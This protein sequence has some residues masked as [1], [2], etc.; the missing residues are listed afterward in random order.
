MKKMR[1]VSVAPTDVAT[2]LSKKN[3]PLYP[4]CCLIRCL[5]SVVARSSAEK[6]LQGGRK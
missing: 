5:D 2:V 1:I 3:A 4:H 6:K